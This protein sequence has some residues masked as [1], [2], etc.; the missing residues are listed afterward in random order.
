MRETY[1]S[2]GLV[3][4]E[5]HFLPKISAAFSGIDELA[6]KLDAVSDVVR[7]AT[8]FPV[9]NGGGCARLVGI[10]AGT[11]LDAALAARSRDA[12]SHSCAHDGVDEGGLSA[13]CESSKIKR[14]P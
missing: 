8:P 4:V 10:V 5:V 14:A 9:S 1:R 3:V 6:G 11:R 13:S 12:V 7:T 2:T